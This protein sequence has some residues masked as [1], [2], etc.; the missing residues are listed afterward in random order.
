VYDDLVI[1]EKAVGPDGGVVFDKVDFNQRPGNY[2]L[3]LQLSPTTESAFAADVSDRA[4]SQGSV[5]PVWCPWN[6]C[7]QM[8]AS[9]LANQCFSHQLAPGGAALI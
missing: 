4:T 7:C 9:M 2:T 1:F 6:S 5:V 8:I 3:T